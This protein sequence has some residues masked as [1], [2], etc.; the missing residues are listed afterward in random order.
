MLDQTG[1]RDRA[2]D[3]LGDAL[4]RQPPAREHRG[5]PARRPARAAARRALRRRWTRA[6]ASGCGSSSAGWRRGGTAV[7]FSTHNVGEAE[8]YADRVLVLAD[9]ELLFARHA[10]ASCDAGGR[11]ATRHDFEARVRAL[12]AR[13]RATE[14][15]ADALAAAQGPADPAPLAAA[16]RRCWSSTRSLIALLI[17]FALSRGP[18]SRRSRS[19]TSCRAGESTF[20]LGGDD[21]RPRRLRRQALR[22]DR[23]DRRPQ[24]RARRCEKVRDGRRAGALIIVPPDIVRAE[25]STG[26]LEQPTVEV[27]YNAEDPVKQQFVESTINVARRRPQQGGLRQAHA[28][29]RAVPRHPAQRAATSPSSGRL[30]RRS[31]CRSPRRSSTRC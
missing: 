2:G 20:D 28:D 10:R 23:P 24:P 17:G 19:S 9:G 14:A 31:G 16:G 13:A 21:G 8:R 1:L 3:E 26:G 12:P 30:R 27:L 6:S 22:V 11:A 4:G 18:T 5:R 29:R 25:L 7:V 15:A